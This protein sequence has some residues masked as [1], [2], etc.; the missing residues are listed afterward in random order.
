VIKDGPTA[1]STAT[2]MRDLLRYL[3][4]QSVT[5]PARP[6]APPPAPLA[7]PARSLAAEPVL[8]RVGDW[9]LTQDSLSGDLVAEHA[10]GTRRTIAVKGTS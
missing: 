8:V 3:E 5:P 2:A 9:T 1:R 4:R 6:T 7:A 10:D